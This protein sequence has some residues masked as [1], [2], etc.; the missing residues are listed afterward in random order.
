MANTGKLLLSILFFVCLAAF[1]ESTAPAGPRLTW[2][3]DVP[4]LLNQ[5]HQESLACIGALLEQNPPAHEVSLG[6]R[7]ALLLL[8]NVLHELDAPARPAVQSFFVERTKIVADALEQGRPAEGARIWKLYNHGFIVQTASVTIAFDLVTGKHVRDEGFSLSDDLVEAFAR[9]CDI[10]FISHAHG[11]HADPHVA[12]V[13]V[14][15]GK[16]VCVPERIWK[17]QPF[18]PGL[19]RLERSVDIVHTVAVRGGAGKVDVINYP[20]HQGEVV[21]NNV[22]A[23]T[24]SD[25]LTFVHTGDQSN[26][27]DFAWIDA[28]PKTRRVDVLMLNCWG[29]D[30]PRLV[31]GFDPAVIIPGH[32]NELSHA[33]DQRQSYWLDGPRLGD[34][35]GISVIMTWGECYEYPSK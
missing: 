3:N 10:L 9:Q 1:A 5:Q 4:G 32:E 20:G 25:G 17:S 34:K 12:G 21:P 23:V 29:P 13:F 33:I 30:L 8:D 15:E 11:D 18:A 35:A 6:R 31:A 2:W 22:V 16:P 14:R 26:G 19:T 7:A 28:L 24:T 27:Q